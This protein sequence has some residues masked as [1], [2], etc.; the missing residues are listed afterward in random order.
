MKRSLCLCLMVMLALVLVTAACSSTKVTATTGASV[1]TT[2]GPSSSV[3]SGAPRYGGTLRVAFPSPTPII[4]WPASMGNSAS[5]SI[6]QVCLET[7]LRQDNKGNIVPWLA[8]S[9]SVPDDLTSITFKIRQGVKFHDGSDLN[10]EVVKWNLDQFLAAQSTPP[11]GAGAPPAGA[12]APPSG[13]GAPPS[14]AGAPP[15]GATGAPPSAGTGAADATASTGT[16]AVPPSGGVSSSGGGAPAS[17][18]ATWSSIEVVDPYTVRVDLKSWSNQTVAAFADAATLIS[19]VSKAAYDKNGLDWMKANP[20]GTGPFTFASMSQGANVKFVKNPDYW[21]KDDQGNKLP[22]LD[23]VDFIFADTINQRQSMMLAG[24]A[25][26]AVSIEPG[27]AAADLKAKG[28]N[29]QMQNDTNVLLLPDTTSPGSPW[30]SK[31]VREAAQHAIDTAAIAKGLGYGFVEAINQI[32]PRST[33]AY[34]ASTVNPRPY[35]VAK[36][37]QMLAEAGYPNG[38]DTTLI[39]SPVG[40]NKDLAVAVQG[41]WQA[42][43]IKA[44]LETPD[45]GKFFSYCNPGKW[46]ANGVMMMGLPAIDPTFIGGLNFMF[47]LVGLNWG[48]SADLQNALIAANTSKE[49][50][51]E[52][53][54]AVTSL[55][56]SD[57]SPLFCM[58]S[59]TGSALQPS[60]MNTGI[61]TRGGGTSFSIERTWLNK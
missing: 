60:V 26:W 7:L 32:P 11:A 47:N 18:V 28:L 61:G 45:A 40:A 57:G 41:Y 17:G 29:V 9:Y 5:G 13:A 25:D 27:Q 59:A 15:A 1:S 56:L 4:G 58:Q 16:S 30:A 46:T 6:A 35:D 54:R 38:F 8:E 12:G 23:E 37:K 14:G 48:R 24:D 3:G 44:T 53:V 34:D 55:M 50:E 39:M 10:A 2:S 31:Q 51:T 20:V 19:M 33:T 49:V 22:Y 36:A 42:I 52:K 43:G 21:K